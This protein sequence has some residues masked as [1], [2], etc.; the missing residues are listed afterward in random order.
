MKVGVLGQAKQIECKDAVH[1]R[2]H[3]CT[4]LGLAFYPNYNDALYWI[5]HVS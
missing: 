2:A 5:S 4:H 1:D 3:S